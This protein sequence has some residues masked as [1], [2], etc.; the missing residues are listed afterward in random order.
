MG[1]RGP[2]AKPTALKVLEGTFRPDRNRGEPHPDPGICTCPS[3]LSKEAKAEW[4]Y[5]VPRLTKLGL[6][7]Y[8]DKAALVSYC[9]AYADIQQTERII[10][11]GG[12]TIECVKELKNGELSI[13]LQQRPEVAIRS[14]ARAT[15]KQFLAEFGL[16]PASRAKL[17]VTP[18]KEEDT[19][20]RAAAFL[21]GK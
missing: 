15:V 5:I 7:T 17:N 8:I 3:W 11:K 6:L 21:L 19:S 9:T 2:A 10:A 20:D 14:A 1:R 13:Y 18:K 16:S 12:F 4:R